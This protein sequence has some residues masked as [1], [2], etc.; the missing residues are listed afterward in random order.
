LCGHLVFIGAGRFHPGGRP[1]LADARLKARIVGGK[2]GAGEDLDFAVELR[3]GL[4]ERIRR[5]RV[6]FRIYLQKVQPGVG[7]PLAVTKQF[8]Q[9]NARHGEKTAL[10]CVSQLDQ[11]IT[12]WKS[13]NMSVRGMNE[14]PGLGKSHVQVE[15][16]FTK[17]TDQLG[18]YHE[19]LVHMR[20]SGRANRIENAHQIG[21]LIGKTKVA[22]T[23]VKSLGKRNDR[24]QRNT[25]SP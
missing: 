13:Q 20:V 3:V 2:S 6:H 1:P 5:I 23:Y 8:Y 15:G 18:E 25:P 7:Y 21:F 9:I 16:D 22:V 19:M 17:A 10:H 24:R 11:L 14:L 4:V 12:P